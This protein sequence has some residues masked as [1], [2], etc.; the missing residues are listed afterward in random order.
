MECRL[1][2]DTGV[3]DFAQEA[4]LYSIDSSVGKYKKATAV[5][6]MCRIGTRW[7]HP[8][9]FSILMRAY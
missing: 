9:K 2:S 6:I 5:W 1:V 8:E 3:L 4:S 7:L